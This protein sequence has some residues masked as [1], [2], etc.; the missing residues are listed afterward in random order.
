MG[1]PIWQGIAAWPVNDFVKNNDFTGK[2]VIPF[3]ASAS[4]GL[5]QSGALLAE[6]AGTGDWLT[7]TRFS[8][9]ASRGQVAEWAIG[10][11]AGT[12]AEGWIEDAVNFWDGSSRD[13][14]A[15]A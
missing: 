9:G 1:Y 14:P 7:G 10:L 11:G 4:S 3:C 2:T 12:A 8:S 5:G 13:V 6:I 15:G